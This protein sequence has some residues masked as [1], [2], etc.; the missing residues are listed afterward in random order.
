[1]SR[2]CLTGDL[3]VE[4]LF[5]PRPVCRGIVVGILSASLCGFALLLGITL[6]LS[7]TILLVV[8]LVLIRLYPTSVY[9]NPLL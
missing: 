4:G 6:L 3:C 1:M 8:L 9:V 2:N 5:D 7:L